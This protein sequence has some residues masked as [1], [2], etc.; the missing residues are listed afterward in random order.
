MCNV[1][2][3]LFSFPRLF[4]SLLLMKFDSSALFAEGLDE[5]EKDD[6]LVDDVEEEEE[7]EEG[8]A[9]SDEEE[10]QKKKKKKKR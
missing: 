7:E 5:Y 4:Y 10:K 8:R 1:L 3:P 9:D 6:F 2:Q